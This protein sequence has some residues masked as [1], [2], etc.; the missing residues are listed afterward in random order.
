MHIWTGG[1]TFP[2]FLLVSK[3][4]AYK[5]LKVNVQIRWK[6]GARSASKKMGH[7]Q[8]ILWSP[9]WTWLHVWSGLEQLIWTGMVGADTSLSPPSCVPATLRHHQH[10]TAP[11]HKKVHNSPRPALRPPAGQTCWVLEKWIVW[12]LLF[13]PQHHFYRLQP[14]ARFYGNWAGQGPV[15]GSAGGMCAMP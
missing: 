13:L 2:H 10:H 4:F 12:S 15:S 9:I 7:L 11:H 3:D 5:G 1:S 6:V 14:R 8:I